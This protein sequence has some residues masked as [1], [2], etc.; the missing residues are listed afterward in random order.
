MGESRC[1]GELGKYGCEFVPEVGDPRFCF[2]GGCGAG[3]V[4]LDVDRDGY[5]KATSEV[6]ECLEGVLGVL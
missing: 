2:L 6:H 1:L 3:E 4:L 5:A